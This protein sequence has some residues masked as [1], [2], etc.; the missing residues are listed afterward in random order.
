[1]KPAKSYDID[2]LKDR[3]RCIPIKE[4]VLTGDYV[5]VCEPYLSTNAKKYVN[6]ALDTNWISSRGKFLNL[7]EEEFAKKVGAKY[8][9]AVSSGTAA[10]MVSLDAAGISEGDEVIVPTSTMISTVYAVSHLGATPVFIDCDEYYQ[11]NSDYIEAHITPKTKAIIPVHIYGHPVDM[12]KIEAIAD[13]YNLIVIYDSA[14]SHGALYKGQ[15]IGGRGLASCYSFY[16][17][18]IVTT[19]EGGMVTTDNKEF[20]DLIRNMK[21]CC[22]STERHFWHKRVG[23]NFHMTNMQAAV[24][25]AQVEE[26]DTLVKNHI[27]HANYYIEQ[28]K[29]VPGLRFPKNASW[30]T[31]VYWMFGFEVEPEFGMNRNDLRLF[32]ASKGIETR[33]FFVPMHLQ[34]CYFDEKN[35]KVFPIAERLSERGMYIPSSTGLTKEDMDRVIAS[36]REAYDRHI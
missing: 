21:D 33:T 1:M 36:I 22:F 30:A 19:G 9:V 8:A 31:N 13:K 26:F 28:L 3:V 17:N 2:I 25:L 11:I 29:D 18:K 12:D 7:F 23:Y 34:P 5:H 6:E 10:L 4:P 14:E 35:D 27:D 16:A 32:M 20:A 15:P 24:G